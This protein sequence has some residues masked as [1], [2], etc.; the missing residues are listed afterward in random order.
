M[1]KK[2]KPE[3]FL[4]VTA[5]FSFVFK[6]REKNTV[7]MRDKNKSRLTLFQMNISE[8]QYHKNYIKYYKFVFV[9]KIF[10]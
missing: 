2:L 10:H 6:L 8:K 1:G 3:K 7:K 4:R 5:E 9:F